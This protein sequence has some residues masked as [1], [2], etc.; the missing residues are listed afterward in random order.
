MANKVIGTTKANI[1]VQ[2]DADMQNLVDAV[3]ADSEGNVEVGHDLHVD[4]KILTEG[5]IA[6]N[7]TTDL[8]DLEGHVMMADN[9]ALDTSGSEVFVFGNSVALCKGNGS[10][11]ATIAAGTELF[12]ITDQ[13]LATRL[14]ADTRPF[15]HILCKIV[16]GGFFWL[17]PTISGSAIQFSA[18]TGLVAG[19]KFYFISCVR[20]YD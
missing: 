7:G 2:A 12:L 16:G 19:N 15:D 1:P 18:N 4:G 14:T 17:H 6:S 13:A 9:A 20:S 11:T 10:V 3:V 5:G 8:G